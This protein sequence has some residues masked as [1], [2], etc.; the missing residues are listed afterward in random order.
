MNLIHMLSPYVYTA[1]HWLDHSSYGSRGYLGIGSM[2]NYWW[3][4]HRTKGRHHDHMGT[5]HDYFDNYNGSAELKSLDRVAPAYLFAKF[6][7]V[8]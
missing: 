8:S 7:S 1:Q 2:N 5:N 4:V 6:S 3:L